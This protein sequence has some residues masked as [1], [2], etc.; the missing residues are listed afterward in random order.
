MAERGLRLGFVGLGWYPDIGGVESHTRDLAR[1][2]RARGHR[3]HALALDTREGLE[4]YTVATCAVEGVE[5]TRMAYRY[6][7]HRALADLVQSPRAEAVCSAWARA[8]GLDLV[9]VHHASGWGLGVLGALARASIPAVMTLHDFWALCPRG[10]MLRTDGEVCTRATPERCAPC[11]A[12]TWP[13]LLPSGGGERRAPA[14]GA[15]VSDDESA[16][17]ARDAFALTALRSAAR[18]F[19]PS[20]STR[21]AFVRTGLSEQSIE[22]VENGVDVEELAR[23]VRDLRARAAPRAELR[24]GVLGTV[25][26]SKGAL[27][28]AQAVVAAR[29]AGLTLEVHG[30]LPSYHG[31]SRYVEELRALSA[32]EPSVRVHGPFDHARLPEILAGLDGVAAPSRWNEVYG[33]TVRE[34]RAAGLPVLVSDA[35]ALPDVIEWGAAGLVVPAEDRAAWVAALRRFADPRE[36]AEWAAHTKLPRS[37]RA[38]ALELERAYCAVLRARGTLPPLEFEPGREERARPGAWARIRAWFS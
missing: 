12:R 20:P 21:A 25:L 23:A 34:A 17:A 27:E 30:A 2:F 28:L 35:G 37:A 13:H 19:T 38:M 22:V 3:L 31:D 4:P 8:A 9:H 29:I 7:D 24:L 16:A 10:Q 5:V 18:L 26:P 14:G 33:L 6:H 11:L 32:R 36:R 1:E 15:E